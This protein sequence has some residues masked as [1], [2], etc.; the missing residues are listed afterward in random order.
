MSKFT[1]RELRILSSSRWLGKSARKKVEKEFKIR[2]IP[3]Q[4]DLF[5]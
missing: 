3:L 5:L 4:L 1:D 2:G